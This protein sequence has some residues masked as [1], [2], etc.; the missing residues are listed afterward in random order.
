MKPFKCFPNKLE[1]TRF[2]WLVNVEL[3]FL[4]A[5]SAQAIHLRIAAALH[6]TQNTPLLCLSVT[7]NKLEKVLLLS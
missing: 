6:P 1:A 3:P 7:T 5:H 4:K 2:L